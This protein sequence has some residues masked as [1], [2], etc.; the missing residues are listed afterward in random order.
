MSQHGHFTRRTID[1]PTG[2]AVN[3]HR[4]GPERPRGVILLFHGLA[5]HSA[6][7]EAV[8]RVLAEA[9]L[10]VYAHDHRGHGSTV[11]QDAPLRRFARK[12]GVKKVIADCKAV[13]DLAV[14]THPGLP[15][16][17]FGHSMGGLIALNFAERHGRALTGLA[18]WNCDFRAGMTLK[19]GRVALAVEKALKGS[20]VASELFRR[21]MFEAWGRAIKDRRTPFDWLSHD[22]QAVEAYRGDPLCGFTP[23]ISMMENIIEMIVEGGSQEA[24]SRLPK[25]LPI[26]LLGGTADPVTEGGKALIWLDGRLRDAGLSDVTLRIVEGARHETLNEIDAYREPALESLTAWLDRCLVAPRRAAG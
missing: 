25:D 21:A 22:P 15:I 16:F 2:A 23:T 1:T 12:D 26:H 5:E 4:V 18:V 13:L 20:D 11:A 9:G 6:R 8:A 14:Q 10:A 17:V 7:Y 3:L 19:A 24:M